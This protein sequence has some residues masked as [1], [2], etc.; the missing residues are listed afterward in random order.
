MMYCK[1]CGKEINEN[2]DI[3]IHCG[4]FTDNGHVPNRVSYT[5]PD[6]PDIGLN[7]ISFLIPIIGFIYYA[8]YR[9]SFPLKSD[10]CGKWALAGFLINV[11]IVICV[12]LV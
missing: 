5:A 2:A 7:F 12:C 3:C 9:E 10:S 8:V 4:V 6:K 1:N 11:I